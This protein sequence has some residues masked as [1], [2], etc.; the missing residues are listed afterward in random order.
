MADVD[1]NVF[2][3]VCDKMLECCQAVITNKN[4]ADEIGNDI[5]GGKK[6]RK[7]TAVPS[8]SSS[9]T[10]IIPT[11]S[12]NTSSSSSSVNIRQALS[13]VDILSTIN[14]TNSNQQHLHLRRHHKQF[15]AFLHHQQEDTQQSLP[16]TTA[17]AIGADNSN[18]Q[19]QAITIRKT[20][21]LCP[22]SLSNSNGNDTID[23]VNTQQQQQQPVALLPFKEQ[24][25][26]ALYLQWKE[27]QLQRKK[28]AKVEEVTAAAEGERSENHHNNN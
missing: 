21:K 9:I 25:K 28:K 10:T 22:T 18:N 4:G 13:A 3:N 12:D 27:D 2:V 20:H 15:T 16:S 14:S 17:A 8:S 11:T 5:S 7:A 19:H 26:H 1:K 24:D 23:A 6:K